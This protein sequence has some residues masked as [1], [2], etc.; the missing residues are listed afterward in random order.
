M[1]TAACSFRTKL[2]DVRYRIPGTYELD[3]W[4]E[5]AQP[6]SFVLLDG[7]LVG[8]ELEGERNMATA[9]VLDPVLEY[10]TFE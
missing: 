6:S 8:F 2:G 3:A 10:A 4:G 5:H 9:M 1:R 7:G